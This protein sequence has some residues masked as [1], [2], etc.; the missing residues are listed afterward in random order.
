M[1]ICRAW[2]SSARYSPA[3]PSS[4][5]T[6]ALSK[7]TCRSTSQ[8]AARSSGRAFSNSLWLM[9]FSQGTKIMAVGATSARLQA[10]WPAPEVMSRW[11][12]PRRSAALTRRHPRPLEEHLRENPQL[13]R[14]P[15]SP[16]PPFFASPAGRERL[17][18]PGDEC[19]RVCLKGTNQ[20]YELDNIETALAGLDV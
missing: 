11:A 10:S 2:K 18:H 17:L 6:S 5:T 12:R 8:P 14:P 16:L 20:E 4:A 15:R 9:P 3:S 13:E 1:S 19:R 7:S